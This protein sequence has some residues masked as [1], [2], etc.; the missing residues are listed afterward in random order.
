MADL[1]A[2]LF[3]RY[4]RV[5]RGTF[6]GVLIVACALVYIQFRM[7]L[8]A[9]TS[10]L[11]QRM[12]EQAVSLDAIV[13]TAS[14]AVN[15][16]RIQ[17]QTWFRLHPQGAE[18]SVL[19]R[20][21]Q[22]GAAPGSIELEQ[23][24][25]PWT[26]ADAGNLTGLVGVRTPAIDRELEMALS[27]NGAFKTIKANLPGST[28]VYYTSAYRFI[29]IYPW[30]SSKK[31]FYADSLK[32]KEFFA[33]VEPVADP[34]RHI[35]W[36]P[37]YL[38]EAGQGVMVTASAGVYDDKAFRGSVSLDLT[39]VQLNQFVRNWDESL[40]T[41]FII[42]DRGQL[43]AHPTLV[44]PGAQTILQAAEAFPPALRRDLPATLQA[45]D[46]DLVELDGYYVETLGIQN[47]PF[48]LVLLVPRWNLV[49]VAL[50]TGVPSVMLLVMGLTLMLLI[51]SS[52]TY[53]DAI[54]PA[55]K[56][57]RYI[58]EEDRGSVKSIPD[59]PQAWRPW[60]LT[61]QNVF[62][63]HTQLVSIQQELDVARRMQQ[64]IVP[65][66]FPSRP[67]LQM[68]A[69]MIPAREVGGDFYDYFWLSDQKLGVVIADVSGKGVPA[70]LF[71]AVARTLLRAIAPSAAGPGACLALANDLLAQD[72][73][74][75][76]FVTLFYGILDTGTGMLEYANGGHNSPWLVAPDGT[77]S[78]LPGTG[79]MALGVIESVPFV[80]A[81][82]QIASGST[83]L[84]YTD[85]ITEA[86]NPAEE[87]YGEARL[88]GHLAASA[89]LGVE[90]LLKRL[91]DSVYEF[92]DGA[93]QSDDITCLAVHYG[94]AGPTKA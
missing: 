27:L 62:N 35:L 78:Q 32:Q 58:Q 65:T 10:S 5:M 88:A 55:Q 86:F 82:A 7:T 92:A 69:R 9:E 25:P 80:Q 48:H 83:L 19:L 46:G 17:A 68:F 37:V 81:S 6:V 44:R 64:S 74:A 76:M 22:P 12:Q 93:P 49:K 63:A 84:L 13:K 39:L 61:I 89:G 91:V 3:A 33:G 18:P 31:F 28:W 16:M 23:L 57:V 59:I 77:V 41:L 75:T 50:E 45:A 4:N 42:N 71:M 24:P 29:N 70:A 53:R 94:A 14:D 52:F 26:V 36:T 11:G 20:A 87:E 47:A 43:L 51:A 1:T 8:G 34:S 54:V 66:R 60:F 15:T 56:L 67:D 72:N 79:G 73:E 38:D 21:L 90:A 30:V 2:A 40:G 85:G